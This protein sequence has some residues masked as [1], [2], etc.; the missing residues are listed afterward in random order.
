MSKHVLVITEALAEQVRL[1][2]L[3]TAAGYTPVCCEGVPTATAALEDHSF[4]AVLAD[5][6][7][8]DFPPRRM[9]AV[10]FVSILR[11]SPLN[12]KTPLIVTGEFISMENIMNTLHSGIAR[13]LPK[14]FTAP[15]LIHALNAELDLAATPA[16][17]RKTPRPTSSNSLEQH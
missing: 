7:I 9:T 3:L 6:I 16:K 1:L 17:H 4:D 13:F 15:E 8:P 10:E 2:L 5:A 12:A 11:A 14:P